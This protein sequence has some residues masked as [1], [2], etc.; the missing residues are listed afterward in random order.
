M[1]TVQYETEIKAPIEENYEYIAAR[2]T[3]L[4]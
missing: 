4:K 2:A 3:L 1:T